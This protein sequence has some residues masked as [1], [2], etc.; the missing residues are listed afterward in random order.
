MNIV[1]RGFSVAKRLLFQKEVQ[2]KLFPDECPAL[3]ALDETKKMSET[4]PNIKD[5]KV[6]INAEENANSGGN[7]F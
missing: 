6:E 7:K 1:V 4:K 2:T 3:V 5:W